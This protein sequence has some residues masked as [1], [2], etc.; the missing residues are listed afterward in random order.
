MTIL[1]KLKYKSNDYSKEEKSFIA[2][3]GLK[4]LTHIGYTSALVNEH[5][6]IIIPTYNNPG[7][8][9][10]TLMSLENQTYTN[11]EV[12]VVDDGSEI[13]VTIPN[14]HYK[15]KLKLIR[16]ES[17]RGVSHAR[18]AGIDAAQGST[19]IF[20]DDDNIIQKDVLN[21]LMLR[22]EYTSSSVFI[23]FR[24]NVD[25]LISNRKPNLKKDWR[26]KINTDSSFISVTTTGISRTSD[27]NQYE[28]LKES[29]FLKNFGNGK[30]IG[31]WDL[32]CMVISH[33]ICIKKKHAQKIGGFD[34]FY[35]RWGMEDISFGA[36]CI[37]NGLYI[38]PAID[39]SSFHLSHEGRHV[40]RKEQWKLLKKN[41]SIYRKF[42]KSDITDLGVK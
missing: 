31:Y 18:N 22:Q 20:T 17:N 16:F 32:P 5:V 35:D 12:I 15:F 9:L 34:T 36:K 23:G 14:I 13:P 21:N 27:S 30:V 1:E 37:A 11:F 26:V 41:L 7:S 29:D 3:S 39:W 10:Q 28:L 42:L 24:E 4:S 40:S 8:I 19:L 33:S 6:S 38:V 25:S 2:K